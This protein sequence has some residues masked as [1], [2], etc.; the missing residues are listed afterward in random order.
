MR[1]RKAKG[2]GATEY[3]LMLAAVL[4]I[5][6]VAIYF[7]YRTAA[8]IIAGTASLTDNDITFTPT[9]GL[10]PD[11]MTETWTWCVIAPDDTVRVDWSADVTTDMSVGT[12]ITL[13]AAGAQSGDDLRI[14]CKGKSTDIPIV[15]AS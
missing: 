6:A 12:P 5:V 11:P 7:L 2:Q 8:P 10:N 3:L 9:T 14:K 15:A 13:S 1:V 4:V